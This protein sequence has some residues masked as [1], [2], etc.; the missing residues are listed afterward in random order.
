MNFDLCTWKP[1]KK[2]LMKMELLIL[3]VNKISRIFFLMNFVFLEKKNSSKWS[4]WSWM[5]TRFHK[6]FWWI[7]IF[8]EKKIRQN[9]AVDLECKQNFRIFFDFYEFWFTWK[10][11]RQNGAIDLEWKQYFTY[12]LVNFEFT[13]KLKHKYL[14]WISIEKKKTEKTSSLK[15]RVHDWQDL[16]IL[17]LIN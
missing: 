12:F 16:T 9:G 15:A 1:W 8:L 10:I 2:N 3:N 6:L 13:W 5:W 4:G 7:S 14:L 11:S 17:I